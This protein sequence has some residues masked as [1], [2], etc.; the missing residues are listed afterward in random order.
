M[1]GHPRKTILDQGQP[2]WQVTTSVRDCIRVTIESNHLRAGCEDR[3]GITTCPICAVNMPFAGMRGES[4]NHFVEQ[5][6]QMRCD[7]RVHPAPRVLRSEATTSF[8]SASMPGV[9]IRRR[10]FHISNVSPVPMK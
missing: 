2:F 5:D 7:S 9:S 3:A 10:G 6:G 8:S 4:G 1:I